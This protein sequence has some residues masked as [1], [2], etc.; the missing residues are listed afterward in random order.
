MYSEGM[1]CEYLDEELDINQ[2]SAPKSTT[3]STPKATPPETTPKTKSK[4]PKRKEDE[5]ISTIFGRAIAS[6]AK[7]EKLSVNQHFFAAM[8]A[9]VDTLSPLKQSKVQL[10]VLQIVN[11]VE[12]EPDDEFEP[13]DEY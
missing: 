1:V 3:N 6:I 4:N 7:P 8:A 9:R 11:Q 5:E 2:N 13:F 12:F 10:E